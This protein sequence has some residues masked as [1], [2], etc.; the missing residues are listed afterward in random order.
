MPHTWC[1]S[2]VYHNAGFG[3]KKIENNHR[4]LFVRVDAWPTIFQTFR[5]GFP[6]VYPILLAEEKVSCSRTQ[7][8]VKVFR[9][10]PEF[11]IL[12][13]TFH[14]KSALRVWMGVWYS[15]FIKNLA[16]YSSH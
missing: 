12:R 15:L 6:R 3:K 4:S 9:I 7:Q 14:R 13:L 11:R 1:G 8:W 5:A 16:H 10:I 2:H